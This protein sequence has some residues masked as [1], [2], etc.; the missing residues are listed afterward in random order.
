MGLLFMSDPDSVGFHLLFG[1]YFPFICSFTVLLCYIFQNV[2]GEALKVP[3]EH[4]FKV[5]H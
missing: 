2:V 4:L 1:L 5:S 3:K